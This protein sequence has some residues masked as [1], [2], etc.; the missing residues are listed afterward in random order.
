MGALNIRLLGAQDSGKQQLADALINS[1]LASDWS[2]GVRVTDDTQPA[3]A[4]DLILLM[5][6]DELPQGANEADQSIRAA[7]SATGTA[8]AVLYGSH[9][10]RHSQALLLVHKRLTET[11]M[12]GLPSSATGSLTPKAKPWAWL[13]DK[14]SDPLCE[15]RLLSTLLASRLTEPTQEAVAGG[16]GG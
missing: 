11:G 13:C 14:C 6:L 7:L 3:S 12:A 10:E 9:D 15:H 8:Y 1:L 2:T 5:G 4:G 16:Q